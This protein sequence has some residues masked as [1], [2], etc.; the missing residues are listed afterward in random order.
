MQQNSFAVYNASAGSGKTYTLVK[1]YLETLFSSYKKDK[2]K[3]ILAVTFTNKAVAEMKERILKNLKAFANEDILTYPEKFKD[4]QQMF[5]SICSN[6]NLTETELQQKAVIVQDG[7]LNNYAAF[8]IVTIDTF[9]HRIIRTFAY[10]L[11]IPQNFE[12]A[13]DTQEILREAID[14]LLSKIGEDKKLTQL[15]IDFAMQKTDDDKSWDI[16]LDLFK[17]SGILLKE[18]EIKH[19]KLL[20]EKTFDDFKNLKKTLNKALKNNQEKI[21]AIA[22]NR[23]HIFEKKGIVLNDIKSVYGYFIKLSK[24]DFNVKFDLVWQTKLIEGVAIYPKRVQEDTKSIIDNIQTEIAEDFIETKK[25]HHEISFLK[26]FSKNLIPLSV[27]NEIQKEIELLKE[28]QNIL[29][30]SEFNSIISNEIKDQPAPFIYERIGERYHNYFID[31][32][33]DTS[34]MQWENLVPLTENAIITESKDRTPNSIMLVGDAKQAIYRWRGG[35]AEQFIN[36]YEKK[37]PF[38]LQPEVENLET[39]WRSYSE[40]I[41]FNNNLFTYTSGLFANK[42]HQNLYKIGNHQNENDKKGG[43]VEISF[44]ENQKKEEAS[45]LYQEQV[46]DIIQRV[47]KEGFE[48]A[49][50]CIITRKRVDGVAIADYLT[51]RD[52]DIISSE[53]L[54][55]NKSENVQFINSFLESLLFPENKTAKIKILFFLYKKLNIKSSENLFYNEYLNLPQDEFFVKISREHNRNFDYKQHEIL[56]FYELVEYIIRAFQLVEYSDAYVQYFLD[57]VLNFTQNK[58]TGIL[59]FLEYWEG[60]KEKLSIIAPEGNNAVTLMTIHKSKGLEFPIVIFPYADM[61]IYNQIDPKAWL[62]IKNEQYNDFQEAYLSYNKELEHYNEDG[63]SIYHHKQS[64]LELDNINLLYVVLTRAKEQLYIIS[65]LETNKDEGKLNNYSGLLINYLKSID[66][67]TDNEN[68]YSFGNPKKLSPKTAFKETSSLPFISSS[69]IDHNLSV[70]TKSGYLWDTHQKNA[71]EKGDLTH[72]ILSKISYQTDVDLAF[73]E[74]ITD[75]TIN[76]EQKEIL[77]PIVDNL[78]SNS[79][80]SIYFK[81]EYTVYNERAILTKTGEQIIPDRF[82]V[83]DNL[84]TII[85]YKTGE[86]KKK[87]TIQVKNYA[88]ALEEIGFNVDKILLVY[89]GEEI[90]VKEVH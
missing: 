79:E 62:P 18:D 12:V 1:K 58:T 44:V 63:A 35:K 33:Q 88:E 78:V 27:I 81:E 43:Y 66:K 60:K 89:I 82:V 71:I 34:E 40:I 65:K 50:I 64:E 77:K 3:H 87:H 68:S 51:E 72:L 46:Y 17:I 14:N 54:L 20:Q 9:T 83:K 5:K 39:N 22:E 37:S 41:N 24:E 15:L 11:K 13:L 10:D 6:L 57:E 2:F 4:E 56:P 76:K 48:L 32:F 70:I 59:G 53:T 30:I 67:W 7:I 55:I 47:Q 23:L 8:D 86:E 38:Y 42:T 74:L 85:D 84:A 36:L 28:E 73:E 75:G 90:H 49:D 45:I 52:V 80:I 26:N 19:V 31:E 69:R 29:L 25:I 61:D 16:G 21:V